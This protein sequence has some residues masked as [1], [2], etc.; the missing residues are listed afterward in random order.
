MAFDTNETSVESGRPIELFEFE[1]G[2]TTYRYT[3]A[4]DDITYSANTYTSEP[5]IR[6]APTLSSSDSGRQQ[7]EIVLPSDNVI[8]A[9][10]VGIVPAER[11][12][13]RILR[14]HRDDSPNGIV[15]WVGRIV[16]AKYEKQGALC[17]LFS[18]SSES[19]LSRPCPNRK[20]QGLCNHTLYDSFCQVNPDSFK[21]ED[22]VTAVS[23]ATITVNGIGTE[24]DDWARGGVVAW[25]NERR[26]VTDHTGNVLTLRLPFP[27]S[28]L[29]ETVTV[30]AG[31]DHEAATCNSKFSNIINFGGFPFVPE[32]DLFSAGLE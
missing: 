31:C 16:S 17:R 2:T 20:F 26:L 10:Y 32:K 13:V 8:A 23:G 6:T 28:P 30:Y 15:L 1:I 27:E 14:F 24:G 3:N 29:G 5:I 21:Y 4:E 9:R 22:E 12:N 25:G 19:A 11:V 7:M 18:V